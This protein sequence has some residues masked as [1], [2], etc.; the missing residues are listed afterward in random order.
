MF[1]AHIAFFR[2]HESPCYLVHASRTQEA[3]ESLQ[4]IS[5]FNSDELALHTEDVRDHLR[6]SKIIASSPC[7]ASGSPVFSAEDDDGDGAKD[8][9]RA[10]T[11]VLRSALKSNC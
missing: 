10:S 6:P 8:P 9:L 5:N 2:L 4:L 1:L 7:A 3:I 11:Q